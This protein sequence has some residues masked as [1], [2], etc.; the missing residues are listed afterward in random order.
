MLTYNFYHLFWHWFQGW[1]AIL[2]RW[3]SRRWGTQNDSS[4]TVCFSWVSYDT[5]PSCGMPWDEES[6]QVVSEGPFCLRVCHLFWFST[7]FFLGWTVH[8]DS[9]QGRMETSS[10]MSYRMGEA[11]FPG[12]VSSWGH[13]V[14]FLWKQAA[15]VMCRN[16][17]VFWDFCFF[18][19]DILKNQLRSY[20]GWTVVYLDT[21][22]PHKPY[23][24]REGD[25]KH[26]IIWL[27]MPL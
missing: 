9:V 7:H 2:S 16:A 25:C 18:F 6:F 11:W 26:M 1:D 27:R 3:S 15:E 13:A 17:V 22:W 19:L 4:Y 14:V 8:L 20:P 10:P 21:A 23:F 12:C 5:E 24:L